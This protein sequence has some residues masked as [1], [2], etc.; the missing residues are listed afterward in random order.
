M[1]K[2]LTARQEKFCINYLKT[3]NGA[4]SAVLAGYGV[5]S[6]RVTASQLLTNPNIQSRLAELRKRTE[7]AAIA[8]VIERKQIL[9]EIARAKLT[10]YMELGKDG[11]W[12]NIGEETQG[13]HAISEIHSRTEYDKDGDSP[14]IYTSVK[15]HDPIRAIQELN[16]MEKV[17]DEST[18]IN[19]LNQTVI[20]NN[21][22][23]LS[24]EELNTLERI[25]TKTTVIG[26]DKTG[27][28]P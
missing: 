28:S 1:S 23:S 20:Q 26:I 11:S 17:Y 8:S 14:T 16:K 21:L 22:A 4:S 25:V 3:S 18:K 9:S 6:V 19:I 24:D 12:V 27:E 5:K 2:H 15:L 7:D 13:A 10:N